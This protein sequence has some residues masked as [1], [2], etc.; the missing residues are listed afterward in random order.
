MLFR[1]PFEMLTTVSAELNDLVLQLGSQGKSIEMQREELMGDTSEDYTLLLRDYACDH[2]EAN[3]AALRKTLHATDNVKLRSPKSVAELLGYEDMAEDSI[4]KPLGLRTL[5]NV[6]VVREGM[7]DKI[8]DKFGSLQQ[9]L[10]NIES[11]PERLDDVGVKNPN[12]LAD[13]LYRMWGKR[14]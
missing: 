9:V 7:A 6:S 13:S 12:I 14:T 2:S 3:A 5:S 11:N 4:M 8:V 1:S 10:D